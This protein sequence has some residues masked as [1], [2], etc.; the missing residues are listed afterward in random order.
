MELLYRLKY[1]L[2]CNC[3]CD[4]NLRSG[5][6]RDDD[7]TFPRA[8]CLPPAFS[9]NRI[10]GRLLH[11][12]PLAHKQHISFICCNFPQKPF[13]GRIFQGAATLCAKHMSHRIRYLNQGALMR[14]RRRHFGFAIGSQATIARSVQ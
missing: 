7:T 14:L 9:R 12:P 8:C 11:V 10:A 2:G 3:S 13:Q 1:L 6:S 5:I 4:S